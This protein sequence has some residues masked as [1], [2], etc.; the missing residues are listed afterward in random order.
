VSSKPLHSHTQPIT[1]EQA[2]LLRT[3]LEEQGWEFSEKPYTLFHARQAK[4]NLSVY[5]KGPKVLIQ[6]KGIEEF[7]TF[8]LEPRVLQ[9]AR[10][11]YE[12]VH[13][14]ERFQPHIGVDESGKG[15]FFGPLVVAGVS[16]SETT[17]HQL[18][19][20]GVRDSKAISSDRKVRDL[21]DVIR[22]TLGKT[23]SVVAI[24]PPKYNELMTSIGN[25]NRLLAWGHSRIIENLLEIT[26]E[27]PR[28]LSDQ[29]A[30]PA[31]LKRALLKRGKEIELVQQTKAE[32]DYAVAAASI[33]AREKL[34]DWF[35]R[36]GEE[37]GFAVPRGA[38]AK[39]RQAAVRLVRERGEAGL[40]RFAKMHFKTA[41]QVL[42]EAQQTTS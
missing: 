34:I 37:L 25:L 31:V 9:E 30:N 20:A 13:H 11:G 14:P 33:L 26:P 15:D 41:N 24:Y 21:A 40:A 29:F 5:E 7:I 32:S 36:A 12:D 10:F 18:A 3:V 39:T 42:Q 28:A 38:S 8:T 4:L 35:D 1:P 22:K 27:C 23:I 16:V 2:K 17:A 6:G 19:D